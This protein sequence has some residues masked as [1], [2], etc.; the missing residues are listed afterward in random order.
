MKKR[1]QQLLAHVKEIVSN[2][3]PLCTRALNESFRGAIGMSTEDLPAA[4]L[5]VALKGICNDANEVEY[6]ILQKPDQEP[7]QTFS[8][9]EDQ[10]RHHKS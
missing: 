8:E 4:K 9:Q 10:I 2:G 3:K 6:L 5:K 1:R 7:L